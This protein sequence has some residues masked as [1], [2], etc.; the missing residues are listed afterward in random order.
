MNEPAL[1][2]F[3]SKSDKSEHKCSFVYLSGKN[4]ALGAH[5]Y[6][7]RYDKPLIIAKTVPA[8]DLIT[9]VGDRDLCGAIFFAQPLWT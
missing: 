8:V 1:P 7:D 4:N 9:V 6:R 5:K 2:G 3:P